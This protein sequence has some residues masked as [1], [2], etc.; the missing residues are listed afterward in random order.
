MVG[1]DFCEFVHRKDITMVKTQL[2][3]TVSEEEEKT[4]SKNSF[5][6]KEVI[7]NSGNLCPGAKRSF[8]CRMKKAAKADG[9]MRMGTKTSITKTKGNVMAD[10]T[11]HVI[12]KIHW[13]RCK[14]ILFL[15]K[16]RVIY[17]CTRKRF[18]RICEAKSFM[19]PGL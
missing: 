15:V 6:L 11:D 18:L 19:S 1:F 16:A 7:E 2:S 4:V 5:I 12:S 13:F 8:I 17:N 14:N 9:I 10:E 3:T